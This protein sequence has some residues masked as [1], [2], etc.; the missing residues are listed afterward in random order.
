[1]RRSYYFRIFQDVVAEV[2]Q[3]CAGYS[4]RLKFVT[5][6][7][8]DIMFSNQYLPDKDP[9]S[10]QHKLSMYKEILNLVAATFEKNKF[11]KEVSIIE[12]E[13]L[14][15]NY[16][17]LLNNIV[18]VVDILY[19]VKFH[20]E[21]TLNH[22]ISVASISGV[23]GKWLGFKGQKLKDLILTG[24]LHDIGKVMVPQSI[25]DKPGKLTDEELLMIQT[26]PTHGYQILADNFDISEDITVGIL[27]HHEREDGSGYPFG[28]QGGDIHMYA[29]IVAIADL[30][31]AMNTARVYR[32]TLSLFS[33]IEIIMEQMDDKL[34]TEI[35]SIFFANIHKC[36][37]GSPV[38]LSD[39]NVATVV[40]LDELLRSRPM[41]K[42]KS[43]KVI[44]LEKNRKIEVVAILD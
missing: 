43:G 42:L 5:I 10:Q 34:N 7:M 16:I 9:F 37:L 29:K 12:C 39:G 14:A 30:Y 26:H 31:D 22:S 25:L 18:G 3:N 21:Y 41:V 8:G 35:C 28:I 6:L 24:L 36:I 11:F 38:L 15:G 40:E 20:H 44:D 33:V 19:N 23:L 13:E 32:P 27:Q 1:V 4:T 2:S 17:D